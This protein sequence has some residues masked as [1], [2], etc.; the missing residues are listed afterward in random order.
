VLKDSPEA[1]ER[2][3]F[4]KLAHKPVYFFEEMILDSQNYSFVVRV[5]LEGT[6]NDRESAVW[7]G[8]IEQ[9]GSDCR[10]YFS[11]L[12]GITRFIQTQISLDTNPSPAGWR[13]TLEHMQNGIRRLWKRSFH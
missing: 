2:R 10:F 4:R 8:S 5:W 3:P 7:R 12:N 1:L 6:N 11:D 13:L 9:V